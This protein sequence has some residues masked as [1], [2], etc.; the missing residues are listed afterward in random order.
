MLNAQ[1]TTF[2]EARPELR[3][4]LAADRARR[5]I[6]TR[7]EE[8]SNLLAG[9][10][11]LEELADETPMRVDGMLWNE[12]VDDGPAAYAAFSEAAAAV[13]AE[14]YPEVRM[15]EDGG[16]F[17]LRLDEEVPARVKPFAE[18]RAAVEESWRASETRDRLATQARDLLP[19]LEDGTDAAA[20]GITLTRERGITR[21]RFIQDA[22]E[23]LVATVFD[24]ETGEARVVRGQDGVAVVRLDAVRAPD[25]DAPEVAQMRQRLAQQAGDA[26]AQDFYGAFAD[27]VRARAGV[28]LNQQAINAVHSNFQ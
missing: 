9:G 10:A 18:V 28:D 3:E 27:A 21:N 25:P 13:T 22:P 4:A 20:S 7:M 12:T 15:L 1:E 2:E 17:A 26:L 14:D 19:G 11:R 24:M 16:I 23:D 8:V 6:E 5:M